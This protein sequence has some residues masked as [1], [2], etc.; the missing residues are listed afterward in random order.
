MILNTFRFK[1]LIA[2]SVFVGLIAFG[3]RAQNE[4]ITNSS[5]VESAAEKE[6]E[7]GNYH[8]SKG[9][10]T[11]ALRHFF[12]ADSLADSPNYKGK[13]KA[14]N[15]IEIGNIFS[16][17]GLTSFAERYFENALKTDSTPE[18]RGKAYA[19]LLLI[20]LQEEKLYS[21]DKHYQRLSE[22][23]FPSGSNLYFEQQL[24]LSYY[25]IQFDNKKTGLA[26]LKTIS[27]EIKTSNHSDDL[28]LKYILSSAQFSSGNYKKALE[29]A[30]L[31]NDQ[32]KGTMQYFKRK[33]AINLALLSAIKSKNPSSYNLATELDSVDK[34]LVVR[35][36]L[37]ILK[38]VQLQQKIHA[39]SKLTEKVTKES[40]EIKEEISTR[41]KAEKIGIML[42][43]ALVMLGAMLYMSIRQMKARQ[44]ELE[45]HNEMLRKKHEKKQE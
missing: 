43:F 23:N 36:G 20:S 18:I 1:L 13:V 17:I 37:D 8:A 33:K 22:L 30:S 24:L 40:S 21:S 25:A 44:R 31:I 14:K 12:I 38:I 7:L 39:V 16:E 41:S 29:N 5:D 26:Q 45:E 11:A 19:G 2:I 9:N 27:E 3:T 42:I 34:A 6:N 15:Q 32:L 28:R 35:T 4:T 10:Y